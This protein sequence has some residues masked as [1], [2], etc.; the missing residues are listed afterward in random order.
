M[1]D[2]VATMARTQSPPHR[3]NGRG[4]D[5]RSRPLSDPHDTPYGLCKC[6]CGGATPPAKATNSHRGLVK[7]EP[8]NYLTGHQHRTSRMDWVAED[9]GY[10]TP[11]WI[12]QHGLSGSGY[13]QRAI[14]GRVYY[15]HRLAYEGAFGSIPEGHY[16]CHR[17]DVPQ[18]V[19]PEHLFTG[20]PADNVRDR[21]RKGRTPL[22]EDRPEAKLT[23]AKVAE[24]RRLH[25]QGRYSIRELGELF[26]VT[27]SC[28]DFAVRGDT[29][30]CVTDPPG[31][32][33]PIAG[34]EA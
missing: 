23:R 10:P 12:W 16:V 2:R 14:N 26:G 6:G 8:V 21:V 17:C 33:Q 32:G 24:A 31:Y 1:T 11:C 25:A 3:A 19:N 34:L 28:M 4:H 27:R 9:R 15:A 7:G 29:W 20:S 30:R 13:G 22:G 5:P 18:C